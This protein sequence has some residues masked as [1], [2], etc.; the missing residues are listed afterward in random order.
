MSKP[1]K[2]TKPQQAES[3][4]RR[5]WLSLA[6]VLGMGGAAGGGLLYALLRKDGVP[7]V[8]LDQPPEKVPVGDAR[9]SGVLDSKRYSALRAACETVLPG[10]EK[11][12]FA[13]GLEA[14]VPAFVE[15]LAGK[16]P[17]V[18]Q[19]L[20]QAL[21]LLD[22]EAV[23]SALPSGRRARDFAD[24][25]PE[26]RVKTL[27]ELFGQ[28][29]YEPPLTLLVTLC[30]RGYLLPPAHGGNLGARGWKALGLTREIPLDRKRA[31]AW[32]GGA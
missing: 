8:T 32:K 22:A 18:K 30:V 5:E 31:V 4:S 15:T 9:G 13:S 25:T 16:A 29:Q 27:S 20:E 12:A 1:H 28:P 14:G 3:L 6:A 11:L 2:E 21:D 10:D 26:L 7:P 23:Q 19:A 24:L 17:S